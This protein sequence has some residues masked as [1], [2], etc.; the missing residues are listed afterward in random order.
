VIFHNGL[1]VRQTNEQVKR[2]HFIATDRARGA[3]SARRRSLRP[4]LA[5]R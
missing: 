1:I 2:A 4:S 5:G 3:E